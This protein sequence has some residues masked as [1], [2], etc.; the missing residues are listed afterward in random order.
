[1]R[2]AG[3]ATCTRVRG[4]IVMM[5][6]CMRSCHS[7]WTA[8]KWKF[9]L[10]ALADCADA[11]A[12]VQSK[13]QTPRSGAQEN[14]RREELGDHL[15]AGESVQVQALGGGPAPTN[16]MLTRL[17]RGSPKFQSRGDT[18]SERRGGHV[19]SSVNNIG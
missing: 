19:T 6:A 17:F 7:L 16:S 2:D 12:K 4:Q 11:K 5:I 8:R 3:R 1:M 13:V 10:A 15:R 9:D 14:L 18:V